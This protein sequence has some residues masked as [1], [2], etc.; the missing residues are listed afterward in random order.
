MHQSPLRH[1][2]IMK[3]PFPFIVSIATAAFKGVKVNAADRR[4]KAK[5]GKT[6]KDNCAD[7][8]QSVLDTMQCIA[9]GDSICVAAGYAPT[10]TKKHNGILTT[11]FLGINTPE[12]WEGAFFLVDLGL[13]FNYEAEDANAATRQ[14]SLRYLESVITLSGSPFGLPDSDYPFGQ[15]FFQHEHALVTVNED[16]KMIEWDQYGDN[17]E[18]EAVGTAVNA[19]LGMLG[20]GS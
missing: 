6:H 17:E 15:T 16:C 19:I 20:S 14:V 11:D 1:F 10:F 4:A 18:Q 2:S 9:D 7:P 13:D 3:V 5:S 8:L 12:Y